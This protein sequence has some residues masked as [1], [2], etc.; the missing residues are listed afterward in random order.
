MS[1]IK[2]IPWPFSSSY[3]FRLVTK[4][5]APFR[6]SAVKHTLKQ[7]YRILIYLFSLLQVHV[8]QV[9][10][11]MRKFAWFKKKGGKKSKNLNENHTLRFSISQS[12]NVEVSG[13]YL[14]QIWNF[15]FLPQEKSGMHVFLLFFSNGE[16]IN[17]M[18]LE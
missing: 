4:S 16:L 2:E 14:Q 6:K 3:S 9:F 15:V 7:K 13:S 12:S 17:L 10:S 5:H 18:V 8:F 11:K 1:P